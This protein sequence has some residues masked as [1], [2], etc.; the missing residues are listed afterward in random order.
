MADSPFLTIPSSDWIAC[1][2]KAF[3]VWDRF[4][5]SPG[6]VLVITRRPVATWFDAD[7]Q[8]QAAVVDLIS[9]IRQHL[10]A[11][12][13][14]KP[15]G[16]NV[17]FNAGESAGQTV[18]HLHVHVIPRYA[19]DVED[20]RG[21]VRHVIPDKGNYLREPTKAP[22]KLQ[23]QEHENGLRL[24][25]GHPDSPLWEELSWRITG[26]RT[27]DV[28]AS[29]VQPSGLDVIESRL[30]DAVQN[31]ARIRIVVSDYLCISDPRALD[32]LCGW[33]DSALDEATG[34]TLDVRLIEVDKL[35]SGPA[36]FH[37]KSWYVADDRGG[38]LSVG[39]SNLSRA[40]LETGVE[41]NLLSTSAEQS[42]VHA[43]FVT[44]FD[45]LWGAATPLTPE[46]I[47]HY[48][49]KAKRYR[50]A[51]F[52]PESP[53]TREVLSPRPWQLEALASLKRIREAGYRRALVAVATG[54]GKT[55]LAAFDAIEVGHQLQRRPRVL[56]IAHRAHML[57][58]AEAAVSQVLD[59]SL[60]VA[61]TAWYIGQRNKLA[62]ELVVASIQ[63]L[64]RPEGLKRLSNEE[65]DY[66]VI[67]E[68]HHA[69]A[70]SYRRV[71]AKIQ[72]G[73]ILGLTATP[74][75][76]DGVDVATIFDDN[77]AH[78][79]TIGD[80]IAEESLVPFHYIGI[81][82][83]VDF[84]QVPWRN[85]RF[86]L[87]ELERR[88][89]RSERMDRLWHALQE[90]PAER[91]ILFC[92]S[93]RHAIFARDWLRSKGV[94]SAAVFSGGGDRC[95][96][97]LEQL[98]RGELQALCVVDMF[99][100]GLDI[101][102][103]DRV[104]ML[105]PTESKIIFLQ[106]LGRGL[107]ASEGKS[108]LLVI[109]FVGNHRI[110]AQRLIH[111]LSLHGSERGWQTLK[112]W[113]KGE[114][115][116]LP[117]GCLL[118][119]E[120]AARDLLKE[121]IPTGAKAGIEAYRALRD[122]LGRR[123][124]ASEL[125][126]RGY[127]P[128]A[129][130][131]AA[132]DWFAFVASE[133]DLSDAEREVVAKF[134]GW[135]RTLETTSLNKSYKMVVLRVLL[136]QGQLFAGA[137]LR[138][139]ARQCRGFLRDHPVLR[140]DLAGDRH[141]VDHASADDATWTAWWTK[142]PIDRWLAAQNGHTWFQRRGNRFVFNHDCPKGLQS[143]LETLTEE[144]VD[145]RLAAYSKSRRLVE[146]EPG[147]C[148]FEAKVSHAGG[149]PILFVPEK[150]K[151]PNRPVGPTVVLLPE[152]SRWEFKFVKVACN[153]AAPV[154]EK[155]NKLSDLLHAWF[156]ADAGLPG[157]DFKVQFA[158]RNGEWHASP[159]GAQ[160]KSVEPASR[161]AATSAPRLEPSINKVAHY[162]THVP[163]YD[164]SAA[165]GGWGPDGVPE[166]LGWV[167][168]ASQELLPGMFVSQVVGHSMEPEI[169]DGQWCLFRPD[170]GGTR[171]NRILLIQSNSSIDPENGGRYTVKRYH[172]TKQ[173]DEE[174]W[175]HQSIELQPLN[176]DYEAICISAEDAADIRIIGE[177]VSVIRTS[178]GAN[179]EPG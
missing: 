58:Q 37:P 26:A 149:R 89:V 41:W 60:G 87:E 4:P 38:L 162:T 92:C 130:S 53:D 165:A 74:E 28:L 122:E 125:F 100:E 103:V 34:G 29:F 66:V 131:K 177:F 54:M 46:L 172:S 169:R 110:F 126:G 178:D 88:V 49:S 97:S 102:A 75:R 68:V 73:F 173:V 175:Q 1:N 156:G 57:A 176:P 27:V 6:H 145:W 52:V 104:V 65:F 91:T 148:A 113:L 147:E 142:W 134:H 83:T 36:S 151:Q 161:R 56:V 61:K 67:D 99:N 123:P 17:G 8:E 120:L 129:V 95:G 81:K 11:T 23:P 158:R 163:V 138:E 78:H 10:D 133:D 31:D 5:V 62:G 121:F 80:G 174:G 44:E 7:A 136:D 124:A 143:V 71:L 108:R 96:E 25:V 22:T 30:F 2:A 153:V 40:A 63:K 32:R 15:D 159:V 45:R 79:A 72:A 146:A 144:L 128:R 164:L 9:D 93:R 141:A 137:D 21:G 139:F 48:A 117:Q 105:R 160:S 35:P 90:H 107:R 119:V 76:T 167:Q 111:L 109:D 168:V 69:H 59:P 170:P 14:P 19:G 116:Q 154:G 39:S 24:S 3:A 179:A 64:S 13:V 166:S 84:R 12:L 101:P 20:P 47:E 82:D 106:Q 114:P 70:P 157:T 132:G 118:D 98:R 94:N 155:G 55:W 16:Y 140:R 112:G 77:L 42:S 115:P 86:E 85:G 50:E 150:S 33:C 51:N 18:M 152:E 127:L 171:Q 135:L 43:Q